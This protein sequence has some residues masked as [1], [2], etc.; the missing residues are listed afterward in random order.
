MAGVAVVFVDVCEGAPGTLFGGGIGGGIGG[1]GGGFGG[2]IVGGGG[3][4]ELRRSSGCGFLGMG[5]RRN[6]ARR[7]FSIFGMNFG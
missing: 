2:G 6:G 1:I 5:C 7:G 4:I 3:I